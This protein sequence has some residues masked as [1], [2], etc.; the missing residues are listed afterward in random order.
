MRRKTN[1]APYSK[2]RQDPRRLPENCPSGIGTISMLNHQRRT[3]LKA[4]G[5]AP[6]VAAGSVLVHASSLPEQGGDVTLLRSH[7]LPLVGGEFFFS[8]PKGREW[9]GTLLEISPL[10]GGGNFEQS[11]RLVFAPTS[12]LVPEQETWDVFHPDLGRHPIFTSPN[13][14]RGREVE[15]I[16]NRYHPMI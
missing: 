9:Q 3:L 7:F 4:A 5:L 8:H 6:A 12:R 16:F 1:M 11:F 14:A 2:L 13:D 15:A 10:P